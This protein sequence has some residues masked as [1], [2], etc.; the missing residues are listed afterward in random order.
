MKDSYKNLQDLDSM[1]FSGGKGGKQIVNHGHKATEARIAQF[2]EDKIKAKKAFT[3]MEF[4]P[5][6]DSL[7]NGRQDDITPD[8]IQFYESL[9]WRRLSE[10]YPQQVMLQKSRYRTTYLR[11]AK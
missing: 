6:R 5:T 8:E 9:Q 1:I 2:M 3:D 7:Y 11:M 10:V 4:P